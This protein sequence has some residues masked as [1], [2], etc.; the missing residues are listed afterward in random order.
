MEGDYSSA[1][2]NT[3]SGAVPAPCCSGRRGEVGA[4]CQHSDTSPLQAAEPTLPE[5]GLGSGTHLGKEPSECPHSP[6]AANC[7]HWTQQGSH[8][9]FKSSSILLFWSKLRCNCKTSTW[10]VPSMGCGGIDVTR[11]AWHSGSLAVHQGVAF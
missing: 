5:L 4:A 9:V 3:G 7:C 6:T 8:I 10:E 1:A 11:G 2:I